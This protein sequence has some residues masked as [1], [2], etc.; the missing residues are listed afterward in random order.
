MSHK[1]LTDGF[2][3]R[4]PHKVGGETASRLYLL[5]IVLGDVAGGDGAQALDAHVELVVFLDAHYVA[6]GALQGTLDDAEPVALDVFGVVLVVE[7][8]SLDARG[9]HNLEDAHVAFGYLRGCLQVVGVL[10]AVEHHPVEEHALELFGLD[11]RGAEEEDVGHD[12]DILEDGALVLLVPEWPL[13]VVYVLYA[14]GGEVAFYG[15]ALAEE[16]LEGEP[17]LFA[18]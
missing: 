1:D 12:G 6:L 14:L 13:N 18:G 11:A 16:H 4:V 17:A 2:R 7:V 8:E 3:E 15:L 5:K 10:V 9:G